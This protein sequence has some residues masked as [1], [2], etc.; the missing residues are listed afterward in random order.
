MRLSLGE[1]GFLFE[2]PTVPCVVSCTAQR[3]AGQWG[4][5]KGKAEATQSL[6]GL[7][8]GMFKLPLMVRSLPPNGVELKPLSGRTSR[9]CVVETSMMEPGTDRGI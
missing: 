2:T 7:P 6:S 4:G 9:N 8:R 1:V 5:C 3:L